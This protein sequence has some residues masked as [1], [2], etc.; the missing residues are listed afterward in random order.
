MKKFGI[1]TSL[2]IVVAILGSSGGIAMAAEGEDT[3][4]VEEAGAQ[5]ERQYQGIVGTVTEDSDIANGTILLETKNRGEVE[6]LLDDDTVY[7]VPGQDE[8]SRDD[9]ETGDRL[10]VLAAVGEDDSY[11][12]LR[13][14]IV[15]GI[16]ARAGLQTGERAMARLG[17]KLE[18]TLR[19]KGVL[20]QVMARAPESAKAGIQAAIG[21]CEQRIERVRQSIR[22]A[23]QGA[24]NTQA[25][26][27]SGQS[28]N[29][30]GRKG[31]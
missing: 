2:L 19:N 20:E 12:A 29:T 4:P 28:A 5:E 6:V 31:R 30:S 8:A 14:M 18:S 15:P 10:A 9:I 24:G 25:Q 22:D 16:T 11:T 27:Q 1:I 3:A 21:N 23:Q 7:K 17:K 26:Q 13:V